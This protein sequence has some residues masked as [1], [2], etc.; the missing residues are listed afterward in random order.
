M[1]LRH[2]A[3]L[4]LAAAFSLA[5]QDGSAQSRQGRVVVPA[6]PGASS[7]IVGRLV[8]AKLAETLGHPFIVDNRPG[9]GTT[10]GNELVAKSAADGMTLLLSQPSTVISG[11]VFPNLRYDP[12]QFVSVTVLTRSPLLLAANPAF[13]AK[14]VQ[15]LIQYA[16]ANP[17]K[18]N[19]GS[20]GVATS[21]HVTGEK[22]KLEAGIDIVHVPYK[23]GAGPAHSDLM[24]GQIQIM[25]DNMPALMPHVKSG[26]LRALATTGLK[27]SPMLPDVPTIAESGVPGFEATSWFGLLAPPATPPEVVEQLNHAVVKILAMPDV[28]RRLA[29]GGAEIVGNSPREADQFYRDELKR[30][31]AVAKTV[32]LGID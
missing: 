22:L 13:P 8:A 32:K 28:R 5:M 12:T 19:F 31:A 18:V 9:A 27:R 17:G 29:D 2:F 15:E 11:L 25:F 14:T 6:G 1:R 10:I 7:D 16:K 4:V 20:L 30:W 21:H 26:R 24:G 3:A 23:G